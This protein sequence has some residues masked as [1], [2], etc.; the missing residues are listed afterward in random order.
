MAIWAR[1][2]C[3]RNFGDFCR[4]LTRA[5]HLFFLSTLGTPCF[6]APDCATPLSIEI[7]NYMVD[8]LDYDIPV[9]LVGAAPSCCVLGIAATRFL[10]VCFACILNRDVH[11]Q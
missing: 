5:P 6:S 11:R 2:C 4:L 8:S 7:L 9:C 3:L 1:M 10:N